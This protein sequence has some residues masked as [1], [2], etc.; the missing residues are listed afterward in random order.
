MEIS[1]IEQ[2]KSLKLNNQSW[3]D[4]LVISQIFFSFQNQGTVFL[5]MYCTLILKVKSLNKMCYIYFGQ[6]QNGH[7][8]DLSKKALVL[9][10]VF[11]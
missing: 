10:F 11:I 7:L 2:Y 1:E 9:T 6:F 4:I 5:Q 8:Y 3:I